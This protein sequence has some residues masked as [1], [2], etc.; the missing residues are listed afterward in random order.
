MVQM[1]FKADVF[2]EIHRSRG[3][4]VD[5][6]WTTNPG[7]TK[8]IPHFFDLLTE[9]LSTYDHVVGGMLLESL[10]HIWRYT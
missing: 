10:P 3:N 2:I 6:H 4:V 9:V 1:D 5:T 8:C 7:V